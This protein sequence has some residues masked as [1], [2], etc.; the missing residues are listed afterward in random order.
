[1]FPTAGY[2][3]LYKVFFASL[4]RQNFDDII[5]CFTDDYIFENRIFPPSTAIEPPIASKVCSTLTIPSVTV[6][7]VP[8]DDYVK[9]KNNISLKKYSSNKKNGKKK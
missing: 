1:M 4:Y 5:E 3:F 9:Y 8:C 7:G 2:L 6:L